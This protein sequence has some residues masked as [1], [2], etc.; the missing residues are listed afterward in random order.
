MTHAPARSIVPVHS[1]PCCS[2]ASHRPVLGQGSDALDLVRCN[3]CGLVYA[4]G[5]HPARVLDEGYG[6]RANADTLI[7]ERKRHA[8]E[9]YDR[10]TGGQLSSPQPGARCLDLGC[11]TGVLLDELASLGWETCGVERAPRA[12]QIAAARHRIFSI[13]LEDE[14]ATTNEVYDLVTI[15]H[16][17]EHM[18]H[19]VEVVRFIARHL[20][21]E[22]VAVIEVPNWEDAARGLW[23]RRYRPLE[24]GD[25]IC[26]FDRD[27][28]QHVLELG[29]LRAE[30]L[31]SR[32]QGATLVMPSVLTTIDAL[33]SLLPGRSASSGAV[34]I[35]QAVHAG[36]QQR[37][38]WR[39]KIL[40][41]LDRVD[42]WLEKITSPDARW[43][44]NLVAIARR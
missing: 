23:G 20:R 5:H 41:A 33:Q 12:A 21:R 43:G 36:Q 32:P 27:S 15:T 38:P 9:L 40:R 28:L 42:P 1:C 30:V 34:A 13:D 6:V 11:N 44:A 37:Q 19:P 31:W 22:G 26:F 10:L 39:A 14:K 4:V 17:L 18:R 35:R 24:L 16:V 3:A 8:V 7:R 2:G 25:H 29:G